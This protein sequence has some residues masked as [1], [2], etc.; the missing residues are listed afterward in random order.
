MAK[1]AERAYQFE[2]DDDDTIFIAGDNWQ[3]DRA[4]LLAGE[5]L[6]LRD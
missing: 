3:F 5:R 4:G 2:R 1:L 6:L